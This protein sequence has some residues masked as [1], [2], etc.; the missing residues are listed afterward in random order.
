MAEPES[1][2]ER[3]LW[4]AMQD[5][6]LP[7]P[8]RQFHPI[9]GRKWCVDFCFLAER[10]IVEVEGGLYQAASGHRSYLGVMRDIEKYNCLTLAQ[11]KVIR[12]TAATIANGEA[13]DLI[14]QCLVRPAMRV[15]ELPASMPQDVIDA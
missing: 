11:F 15:H 10:V 3:A 2:L 13:V 14:R 5:A 8:L 9:P 7:Q 1:A 12:I 4:Q 6:G